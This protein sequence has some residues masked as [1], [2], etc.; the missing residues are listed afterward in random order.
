[1][2]TQGPQHPHDWQ[3]DGCRYLWFSASAQYQAFMTPWEQVDPGK[4]LRYAPAC[5]TT[6]PLWLWSLYSYN[7]LIADGPAT[8][9]RHGHDAVNNALLDQLSAEQHQRD[10]HEQATKRR[11]Q[12]LA[13]FFGGAD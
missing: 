2:T 8:T 4:R 6:P 10:Q 7:T 11:V 1:M 12:D 13:D 9:F 5:S 3:Q